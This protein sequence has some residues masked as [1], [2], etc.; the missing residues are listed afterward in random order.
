MTWASIIWTLVALRLLAM[1]VSARR[2]LVG[3]PRGTGRHDASGYTVVTAPGGRLDPADVAA[4]CSHAASEG[5]DIVHLVPGAAPAGYA[6]VLGQLI[7]RAVRSRS[8][9][10]GSVGTAFALVVRDDLLHR[11]GLDV[12]PAR[13]DPAR[14]VV[15]ARRLARYGA[16]GYVQAPGSTLYHDPFLDRAAVGEA[17]GTDLYTV[18]SVPFMLAFVAAGPLVAPLSGWSCVVLFHGQVLAACAG[19]PVRVVRSGVLVEGALRWFDLLAGWA[20]ALLQRPRRLLFED[21]APLRAW[22]Q[23]EIAR[24]T[25]H[26]FEEPARICPLCSS[27]QLKKHLAVGDIWQGKPGTLRLDACRECRHVFQNPRLSLDGLGFYYRDFYDGLGEDGIEL[28]FDAEGQP[29]GP[30]ADFVLDHGRPSSWLDV[31]C[32]HGHFCQ[33]IKERLPAAKVD[34]LD[35]SDGV[36]DARRRGWLDEAHTGLFPEM[37]Q[38]LAG[39]YDV[40]SMSHYLEH[41]RDPQ[42]EVRAAATVLKPGGMLFIEVPDPSSWLGHALGRFWLPWFQP[43]HQ[44]FVQHEALQRLMREEGLEPIASQRAEAH[45]PTEGVLGAVAVLSMLAPT[46]EFPWRPTATLPRR[47]WH[48]LVWGVGAP[49]LLLGVLVDRLTAPALARMG[50]SNAY[51]ALARKR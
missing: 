27:T 33:A 30:R 6:V 21:A 4:A 46:P 42:A 20:R 8:T 28:L 7:D 1:G 36:E 15:L 3:V 51:R 49:L 41:T 39:T 37:A 31:G 18:F 24:G 35:L 34:G 26:F 13:T 10:G 29:Y 16:V 32:G 23:A 22:Y 17:Y 40:V 5:L 38:E 45:I 12:R 9:S 48:S 43:Q 44:H 14:H 50:A 19:T 47:M 25:E 2:G 11:A